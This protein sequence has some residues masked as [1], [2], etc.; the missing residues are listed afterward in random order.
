MYFFAAL[1]IMMGFVCG[2]NCENLH[3]DFRANWEKLVD[4]YEKD[5]FP[6]EDDNVYTTKLGY[7]PSTMIPGNTSAHFLANT[8]MEDSLVE[9]VTPSDYLNI[10][11]GEFSQK[12]SAQISLSSIISSTS[13]LDKCSI[14]AWLK[15]GSSSSSMMEPGKWSEKKYI[16][17]L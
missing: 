6:K 17:K 2:N 9:K 13:V 11:W 10:I 16:T 8:I 5:I 12:D 14:Q 1:K 3:K 15:M 4:D 7:C